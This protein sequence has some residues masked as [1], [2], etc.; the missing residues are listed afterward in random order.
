MPNKPHRY[1]GARHL[2]FITASCYRRLPLLG[3]AQDR[4]LLLQV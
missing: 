1:Y 2:H 3:R 4:D